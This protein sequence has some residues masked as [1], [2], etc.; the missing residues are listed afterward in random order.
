M[1]PTF[2]GVIIG[3]AIIFAVVCAGFTGEVAG[4]KGW[5]R[6]QWFLRGL[7][8]GPLALLAACG[9]PDK[10]LR[11]NLRALVKKLEA[12]DKDKASYEAD[13]KKLEDDY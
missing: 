4:S 3:A 12:L 7:L 8:F 2:Q 13:K 9:L 6:M 11:K 5:N 1:N 10:K